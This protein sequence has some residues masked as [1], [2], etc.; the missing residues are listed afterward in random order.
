M[1][2]EFFFSHFVHNI[3]WMIYLEEFPENAN[4]LV[5]FK[6]IHSMTWVHISGMPIMNPKDFSFEQWF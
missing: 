6:P 5:F 3:C 1:G 4:N 2:F